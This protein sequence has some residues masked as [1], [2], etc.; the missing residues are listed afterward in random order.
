MFALGLADRAGVLHIS[1][2][3]MLL[4]ALHRLHQ[5][6]STNSSMSEEEEDEPPVASTSAAV[7]EDTE[8]GP[9][10]LTRAVAK[11]KIYRHFARGP[12]AY[13]HG[14]RRV[15]DYCCTACLDHQ[16]H[17]IRQERGSADMAEEE[18]RLKGKQRAS[19]TA[20]LGIVFLG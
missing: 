15:Y 17:T 2:L 10:P 7:I 20:K 14:S 6:L 5:P 12:L 1:R 9:P 16:I 18:L 11:Q 19:A 3:D 4:L 13:S 8:P